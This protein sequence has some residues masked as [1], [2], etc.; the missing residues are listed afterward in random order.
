M[1]STLLRGPIISIVVVF[2]GLYWVLLLGKTTFPRRVERG[3]EKKLA[4]TI[5]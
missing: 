4:I 5:L 3:T 2:W 1:R